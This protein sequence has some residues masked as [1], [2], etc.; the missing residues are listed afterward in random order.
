[1][2]WKEE[3][4]VS[5]ILSGYEINHIQKFPKLVITLLIM[6]LPHCYTLF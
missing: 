6:R 1:M 3:I 5:K 4:T 2:Q